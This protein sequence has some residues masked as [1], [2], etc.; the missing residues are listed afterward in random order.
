MKKRN[1]SPN[2]LSKKAFNY[3]YELKRNGFIENFKILDIGFCLE[4][5]Y[6]ALCLK[7]SLGNILESKTELTEQELN[8]I[9][10]LIRKDNRI[11]KPLHADTPYLTNA[12]VSKLTIGWTVI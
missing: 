11:L 5:I 8:R 9:L 4:Y 10:I 2:V 1:K 6:R 7:S 3:V 12:P